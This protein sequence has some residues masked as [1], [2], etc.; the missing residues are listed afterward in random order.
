MPT[1]SKLSEEECFL[2]KEDH[3]VIQGKFIESLKYKGTDICN[4]CDNWI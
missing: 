4:E 2:I 1:V 3:E